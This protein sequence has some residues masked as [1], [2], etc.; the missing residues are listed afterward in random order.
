M[1][2][3][4]TH[5][6]YVIQ[7]YN[8]N[9]NL[10]VVGQYVNNRARILHHCIK[11]NI[12]FYTTPTLA[13]KYSTCPKCKSENMAQTKTKT[14]Q[15]YLK[16]LKLQQSAIIPMEQYIGTMIKI[17]HKCLIHN[18]EFI[19]SPNQVL[20]YGGCPK[21]VSEHKSKA[22][23][24]SHRQYVN[25]L[26]EK[27]NQFIVLGE[28]KNE[29][30]KILHKCLSCGYEWDV[31]PLNILNGSGCPNCHQKSKGEMKIKQWLDRHKITYIYQKIF[32]DCIDIKPLPF[33]FYFPDYNKCIEYDG[34]QHFQPVDYFGGQKW[35][36]YTQR[37]DNIK[38][39][40]CKTHNILLLRI[41]YYAEIDKELENFL[42]N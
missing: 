6:E 13:R 31:S 11:H 42:F 30:I 21:C 26:K 27:N 4:L 3:K 35:F 7:L 20:T 2:A 16:E 22:F 39:Q 29:R 15:Q 18:L 37:H 24:K 32:D 8:I 33:D 14:H 36:E 34:I 28:Y 12:D 38:T 23:I 1:P 19:V 41:P 25:D 10:K 5:E 40:Y 17:K 9:P